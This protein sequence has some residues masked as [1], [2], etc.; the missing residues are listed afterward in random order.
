M[1]SWLKRASSRQSLRRSI[2]RYDCFAP[3]SL[4]RP[5][6][7]A[8][9]C[10]SWASKPTSA[11]TLTSTS[12]TRARPHEQVRSLSQPRRCYGPCPLPLHLR[13]RSCTARRRCSPS[14]RPCNRP[15]AQRL[16]F[17]SRAVRGMTVAQKARKRPFTQAARRDNQPTRVERRSGSESLMRADKPRTVTHAT[18]ST[19]AERARRHG[20][21]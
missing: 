19:P 9:A 8:N 13:H 1:R 11:S 4:E 15:K 14:R 17:T 20:R 18:S 12:T 16:A 6:R 10:M 3:P 2:A 21:R 5:P 7:A